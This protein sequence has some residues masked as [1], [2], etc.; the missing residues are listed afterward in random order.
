MAATQAIHVILAVVIGLAALQH[1]CVKIEGAY[2]KDNKSMSIWD[3]FVQQPGKIRGGG[4]GTVTIDH[5]HLYPSDYKLM[6]D[7]GIKVHRFSF[8][9]P[10]IIPGGRRG[11]AVNEQGVAFYHR[12][13]DEMVANGITPVATMYHWDLPQVLQDS[14]QG[15]LGDQVVDDFNYFAS[16][17]FARF[18]DKIKFWV[19]INEPPSICDLGYKLGNYAPGMKGG[20]AAMYKCAHNTLLAHA[21]AVKTYRKLYSS[22][23]AKIGF[24]T[25]VMWPVPLTNSAGDIRAQNNKLVREFAW[26]AD[27]L[28]FGDYPQLLKDAIQ[29]DLPTFTTEQKAGLKGSVDFIG[30][31]VYTARYVFAHPDN[32][33]GF[34]ESRWKDGQQIGETGGAVWL[35]KVPSSL[36]GILRY[37]GQRYNKPETW[38]TEFGTGIND[39]NKWTGDAALK[40]TFRT[41]FYSQY[42]QEACKAITES[43]LNVPVIL[44]WSLWDNFEWAEGYDIRYGLVYV[45]FATQ[46][47]R[48]K[49]S[50]YWWAKHFFGRSKP[51]VA[52]KKKK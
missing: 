13:I 40:D 31:N 47:R 33:D 32:P 39:E 5:Y 48:L 15:W 19:T 50:G 11:S 52:K 46:Q 36:G 43:G 27:P 41:T 10:R 1:G 26:L 16:T 34:K 14:Y 45:D 8:S 23:G 38:V 51:L 30:V 28:F 37:V 35:L 21:A 25:N 18:G 12:L 24:S 4:N 6:R 20:K 2:N 49:Q 3:T 9:W 29:G 17:L 7:M 44:A 42:L 22:Q